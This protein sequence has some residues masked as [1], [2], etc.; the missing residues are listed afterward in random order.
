MIVDQYY[1]WLDGL[2]KMPSFQMMCKHAQAPTLRSE[3]GAHARLHGPTVTP[4]HLRNIERLAMWSQT[5][6][7]NDKVL[8]PPGLLHLAV[9]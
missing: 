1:N 7:V 6:G 3:D 8:K 5:E 2:N 4:A 9:H